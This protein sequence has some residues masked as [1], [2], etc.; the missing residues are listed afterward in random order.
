[1][2]SLAQGL[3]HNR[4][5][6]FFILLLLWGGSGVSFGFFFCQ[7]TFARTNYIHIGFKVFLQDIRIAVTSLFLADK[8][9]SEWSESA[10]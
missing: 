5:F 3:G 7:A 8:L 10:T 1:M 2:P 6:F 4:L 9:L